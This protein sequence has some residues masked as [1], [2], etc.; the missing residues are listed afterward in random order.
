MS[1]G[2]KGDATPET[3]PYGAFPF[4]ITI[5]ADTDGPPDGGFTEVSGLSSMPTV[6]EY[7]EGK[8]RDDSVLKLP[9]VDKGSDVTLKR[10]VMARDSLYPW[11]E[12]T[13]NGRNDAGRV[14]RIDLVAEDGATRVASWT[15]VNAR[16]IAVT[17]PAL[18]AAAA[19]DVAVEELVL[20]VDA[21]D[22]I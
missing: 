16:P 2:N 10:G 12:M 3:N 6:M 5:G 1:S 18:N 8:A 11:L 7:R 22:F 13:R 4:R 17:G 20:A 9:A 15:L 14:L 19:T 21:I